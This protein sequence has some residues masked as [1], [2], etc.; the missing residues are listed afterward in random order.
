MTC[1]K[2]KYSKPNPD[3]DETVICERFPP[4]LVSKGM[5][6]D[7]HTWSFPVVAKTRKCGE[8]KSPGLLG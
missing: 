1:D 2:C 3:S 5:G 7:P 6:G 4:T 8:Y